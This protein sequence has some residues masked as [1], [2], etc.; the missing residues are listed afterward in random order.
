MIIWH[1]LVCRIIF[2]KERPFGGSNI[3]MPKGTPQSKYSIENDIG[4]TRVE[5]DQ[6]VQ[7]YLSLRST[8]G[9][10][11]V[12]LGRQ[13]ASVLIFGQAAN[14]TEF[15]KRLELTH[16]ALTWEIPKEDLGTPNRGWYV[17]GQSK[18][19]QPNSLRIEIALGKTARARL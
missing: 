18:N 13:P 3:R 4:R 15:L 12:W 16:P 11:D 1:F 17:T 5:F 14:A 7:G 8:D 19:F 6:P 2:G 10:V 9:F